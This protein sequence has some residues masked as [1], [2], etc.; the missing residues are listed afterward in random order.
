MQF[1]NRQSR[2]INHTIVRISST[3]MIIH[4][5]PLWKRGTGIDEFFGSRLISF[6]SLFA[7]PSVSGPNFREEV[8]KFLELLKRA[9]VR[10]SRAGGRSKTFPEVPTIIPCIVRQ[11]RIAAKHGRETRNTG[12]LTG[13]VGRC[14]AARCSRIVK[15]SCVGQGIHFVLKILN[16]SQHLTHCRRIFVNSCLSRSICFFATN[17]SQFFNFLAIFCLF[18]SEESTS[19]FQFSRQAYFLSLSLISPL[20]RLLYL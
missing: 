16:L 5:S 1:R 2:I 20:V 14:R 12:R 4:S 18:F 15:F 19:Q 8:A 10:P 11:S 6:S 13:T 7:F 17:A 9:E 3:S